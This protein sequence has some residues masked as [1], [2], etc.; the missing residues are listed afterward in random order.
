MGVR[1]RLLALVAGVAV[2]AGAFAVAIAGEGTSFAAVA[3]SGT[4][5][6]RGHQLSRPGTQVTYN[7]RLYQALV[8]H[9]AYVRRRL[10]PG[11]DPVAVD[12]PRRLH[13]RDAPTPPTTAT[14]P[15]RRPPRRRPPPTDPAD[16]RRRRRP[17]AR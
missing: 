11:R 8:T 14:R 2:A 12:G 16:A 15:P 1:R 13:R 7:G 3:C 17:P 10:E 9:T 4:G 6:G 5:L